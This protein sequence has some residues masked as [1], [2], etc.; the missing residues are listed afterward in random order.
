MVAGYPETKN[1]DVK[2]ERNGTHAEVDM[3]SDTVTQPTEPMRLAMAE[4]KVGDDV[5][6]DDPTVKAL[7][8]HVADMLGKEAAVF[9]T[10]GTMGNLLA[11]SV[12]CS[13]RGEE[14]ICGKD[15]HTFH[16]EQGGVS[17][18]MG[19]VFNTVPNQPDGTIDLDDV[20]KTIKPDDPHFA[21][22]KLLIIENTQNKM[23]GKVLPVEYI[24]KASALCKEL[25]LAFHIDGARLWNAAVALGCKPAD[26][27]R[28]ADTVTVC[29]S[30]GLGAPVGSVLAGPKDFIKK[31][32]RMRKALGGGM[33][34][35]GILAAAG[36][37]A[38][39]NNLARLKEDH[40][41]A[42]RLAKGLTDLG[43]PVV[44][45]DSNMCF[46]D[47]DNAPHMVAT[48]KEAGVRVLCTDG[49]R[50]IRAVANLHITAAS[51]D[52]VIAAVS[53]ALHTGAHG[54]A[55]KRPRTE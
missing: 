51:I 48:L 7:E 43:L 47:V 34:Q 27:V 28:A 10:S 24:E 15:S 37:Y 33:R 35:A 40:E 21:Q 4:A 53:D 5:F 26:L 42:Q 6:G 38:V 32:H 17:S 29:L 31:A 16:Y 55:P 36:L 45:A 18:L 49:K 23:G 11:V 46:F 41:N 12:H 8:K 25:G 50:R 30:K 2:A 44:P 39:E 52:R 14:V 20:R 1:G 22:A 3:R 19:V 54:P 13:S 9:V